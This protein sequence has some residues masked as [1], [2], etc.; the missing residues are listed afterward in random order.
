MKEKKG[1]E[2]GKEMKK[3]L[4]ET[5]NDVMIIKFWLLVTTIKLSVL[6]A[7]VCLINEIMVMMQQQWVVQ[8]PQRINA[9]IIYL[10]TSGVNK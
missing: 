2:R 7:L 9:R 3:K 4:C 8:T 1:G 5:G 10:L 6:V